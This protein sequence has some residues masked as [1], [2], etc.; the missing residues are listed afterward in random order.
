MAEE[1]KRKSVREHADQLV[2]AMV[3]N[4]TIAASDSAAAVAAVGIPTFSKGTAT[5]DPNTG[6]PIA[7][8]GA[9]LPEFSDGTVQAPEQQG[10]PPAATEGQTSEQILAAHQTRLA[11]HR[12]REQA[13][14]TSADGAPTSTQAPAGAAAGA[15]AAE[16]AAEAIA[17]EP[18]EEYETFDFEDP[19]LNVTYPVRVPKQNLESAKRGYGRRSGYDRAVRYLKEAEPT[20]RQMVEDGRIRG[21]LPML[22]R[23]LDDPAYAQ[24]VTDG[25]DRATRGLPLIEQARQEAAAVVAPAAPT[26]DFA[27]EDP[28]FAERVAP[29][30]S[31]LQTVQQ[32][33]D[34]MNQERENQ[35]RQA[36]EQQR[37]NVQR[38]NEMAAAHQDMHASMPELYSGDLQRD[39]TVWQRTVDFARDARYVDTYGLRA[40]LFFAAQQ[41]QAMERER[42]AATASP[43]A[44]ALS[45]QE[46]Q[47]MELA[48][49]QA[50]AA[51]RTVGAGAVTHAP[52]P[53]P[54]QRPSS[55]RADGSLKKPDEILSDNVEY[56]RQ[57]RAR[58]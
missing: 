53:P 32:Q 13:A 40:G 20:L 17:A 27:T 15:Q 6:K 10:A 7:Q 22:Q 14:G 38:N 26:Y 12:A 18:P 1:T 30:T 24:Y 35:T 55:F 8:P 4:G 52:P 36:A 39:Q 19:D 51:S 33:L 2:N 34:R 11:E 45:M 29:I 21:V 43:A 16:A 31:Q 44:A 47:H 57:S 48:R 41:I 37:V 49:K 54:P 25:Y 3:E 56:I 46:N 5:L 42:L 23:A 58:A 28:F 50:A 9:E